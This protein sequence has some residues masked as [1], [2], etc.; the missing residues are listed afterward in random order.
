[1]TSGVDHNYWENKIRVDVTNDAT[2]NVLASTGLNCSNNS[3]LI[4]MPIVQLSADFD[5]ACIADPNC[6]AE[7]NNPQYV[8]STNATN[9]ILQPSFNHYCMIT[10]LIN[11]YASATPN[12]TD[13]D[14]ILQRHAECILE[15]NNFINKFYTIGHDP[16]PNRI[17]SNFSSAFYTSNNLTPEN[18]PEPQFKFIGYNMLFIKYDGTKLELYNGN[19]PQGLTAPNDVNAFIG[20]REVSPG[21][22]D[23]IATNDIDDSCQGI[24][25]TCS[26]NICT[27]V[28]NIQDCTGIIN[29]S[30]NS[31]D[32]K[33][34]QTAASTEQTSWKD[35]FKLVQVV[36]PTYGAG[37][38]IFINGQN[39]YGEGLDYTGCLEDA[40]NKIACYA[41]HD[42]QASYK[43]YRRDHNKDG[44]FVTDHNWAEGNAGE[45]N[46]MKNDPGFEIYKQ[47]SE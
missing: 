31:T 6:N 35:R 23:C 38:R 40:N 19:A 41:K 16:D 9:T 11:N 3:S 45:C 39:T 47:V 32:Y 5:Q 22:F 26:N 29:F 20:C 46:N 42:E 30:T 4:I 8:T 33:M 17:L 24:Q 1:M 34:T 2:T 12:A 15:Q 37:I 25:Y 44:T 7:F 13:D 28:N 43:C 10:D 27:A 14:N 36:V 21:N 18:T